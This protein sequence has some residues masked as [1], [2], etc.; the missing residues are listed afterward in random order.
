MLLDVVEQYDAE[1]IALFRGVWESTLLHLAQQQD[2]K[3]IFSFLC[4]VGILDLDEKDKMV[5]F[6]VPNEF[7]FTQVKK[8]FSKP[9]KESINEVYNPHFSVKF[10]I[11]SKFSTSNPLLL[12]LKKL[13]HIKET[14]HSELTAE[15]KTIKTELS[16][17]FGILF[18]PKFT[19]DTFVVWATNNIAFSAAKAVTANP[20][21]AYNPLF[22]YG[23]V[24]L[25]KTHLMQAIGNEIM[26]KHPDKVVVYLPV[27]KLVDEIVTAIKANKLTN[28]L[29]KFDDVDVLLIDDVQF[30]A[31]K[32][33]TQEIFHNIFNDFQGR[34]KQII[35]SSDRPPKELVHIEPRLKS[36]FSLGLIADIK[37]P[38]FETRI[39]ILQ[40]KL[41]SKW[42]DLDFNLLEILAKYI[43]EN[44]REL[45]WALNIL[46]SRK[47]ILH[48][49]VEQQDV[50]ECLKTLWYKVEHTVE[51]TEVAVQ[52]NTKGTKNFDLLVD[53]VAQYY[54]ISVQELKS[55][56][57]KKEITNARQI[58]ML[59]AKKY[60]QRT[61]ERIGDHFGGKGHAAVIY[62]I[63]NTEKKIKNDQDISHDYEVFVDRLG[64]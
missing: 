20:G 21:T 33:R 51:A 50:F 23:S 62:A 28:V 34:Q 26:T 60:F 46:L 41:M 15:K 30:L 44:V 8:Y 25:G 38:D 37:S 35:L 48:K 12:D 54:G 36:R 63:N 14:K 31:G 5:V 10:V 3:K 47:A 18:D 9:L 39:A 32:D 57:R 7:V 59:L 4:K 13:L 56:S 29:K 17:F 22:L 42:E 6:G 43:K 2:H 16:H 19:F 45:E 64:K 24:G 40:S 49:D 52:S 58:L 61:L 53:M 55:E 27:T 1:K 11:Y